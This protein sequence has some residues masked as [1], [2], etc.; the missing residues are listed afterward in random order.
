VGHLEVQQPD[1]FVVPP[2]A[3]QDVLRAVVAVDKRPL[4]GRQ[5]VDLL[6]DRPG[7]VRVAPCDR[8]VVGVDS[9]LVERSLVVER[10]P[11]AGLP[12]RP[13]VT[14]REKPPE[15]GGDG[16]LDVPRQQGRLPHLRTRGGALDRD[17]VV[18]LVLERD[19]GNAD[20]EG[21]LRRE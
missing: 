5:A 3:H 8:P 4:R 17:H 10:G 1:R 13:G 15:T 20:G 11:E 12:G 18:V 7:H 19:R 2:G 16:R 21:R 9:E 14:P 6:V